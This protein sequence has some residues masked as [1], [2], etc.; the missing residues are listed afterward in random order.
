MLY[1]TGAL[2][3]DRVMAEHDLVY[4]VEGDWEIFQNGSAYRLCPDD[5]IFLNAGERHCGSSPCSDRTKTMYI[6]VSRDPADR[7]SEKEKPAS[8]PLI[9]IETLTR[10]G[11]NPEVKRLF[12]EIVHGYRSC[13]AYRET[14]LSALFTLLLCA[15][16]GCL[17][18]SGRERDE[19]ADRIARLIERNPHRFF[20]LEELSAAFHLCK[21]T[22]DNRFRRAYGTSVYR[23][24]MDAK[25]EAVRTCLLDHPALKLREAAENFGFYDEF[26]LSKCFKQKFGL[27][28]SEY[29]AGRKGSPV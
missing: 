10:C 18:S 3:P 12:Q 29:R 5:V 6:H 2:H 4:L 19:T 21:K 15:L 13:S 27:P 28:P 11:K 20:S 8:G 26:H 23:Y 24:Q 25:L 16:A 17:A 9:P 22:V 14:E 1:V 7:F